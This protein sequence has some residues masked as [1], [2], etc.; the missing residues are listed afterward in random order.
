MPRPIRAKYTIPYGAQYG[1]WRANGTRK[2]NGTDYHCPI[3]TPIYGTGEGGTVTHIGYNGDV[4][5]G[6]G[7]NVTIKYGNRSTLD[8]HMRSRTPLSV[9]SKVGP[10]TLVGYV[11][12][13]GNAVNADPKGPHDHHELRINGSLTNPEAYYGSGTAGGGITPIEPEKKKKDI[14]MHM[15]RHPNGAITLIGEVTYQQLTANQYA[16]NVPAYGDY[17]QYTAE[18]Y[19][20]QLNDVEYRRQVQAALIAG[21][22]ALT[23]DP[24]AV[25]AKVKTNLEAD[26]NRL[27]GQIEDINIT[28]GAPTAEEVAAAVREAIIKD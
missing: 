15:A 24:A 23:V 16:N 25:A 8:A 5:L 21:K 26:F 19:Q 2:H 13:T 4:W 22:S 7:H 9:G 28:V 10:N 11:G 17:I 3:G 18:G 20:Q 14:K 6:L 1:A 27:S 12:Q